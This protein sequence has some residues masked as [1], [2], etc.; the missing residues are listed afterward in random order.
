MNHLRALFQ[1]HDL[2]PQRDPYLLGAR[3]RAIGELVLECPPSLVADAL[4]YI[5][6][7][8]TL[9]VEVTSTV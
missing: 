4:G 9:A 7:R 8:S 1:H 2:L 6:R 5:A 3:N